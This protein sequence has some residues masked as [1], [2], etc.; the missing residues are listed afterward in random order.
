MESSALECGL[1]L[2][3]FRDGPRSVRSEKCPVR[4]IYP[5]FLN[6]GKSGPEFPFSIGLDREVCGY[7][8]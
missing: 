5:E 3:L 2:L 7:S 6:F 4:W 8:N 1:L